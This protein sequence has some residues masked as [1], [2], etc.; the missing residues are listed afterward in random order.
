M[1]INGLDARP[2]MRRREAMVGRLGT[3][4][5]R[6][7]INT[8]IKLINYHLYLYPYYH[9]SSPSLALRNLMLPGV[10]RHTLLLALLLICKTFPVSSLSS[11]L[12]S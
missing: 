9:W 11:V 7:L 12:L 10:G 1:D 6:V 5:Q 8:V 2:S 3:L 4:N